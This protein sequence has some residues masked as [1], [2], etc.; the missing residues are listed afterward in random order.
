MNYSETLN[1]FKEYYANIL[2][3]Q[4]H[5]KSKA[6]QTVKLL[7]ELIFSNMSLMQIR[8]VFCLEDAKV[9]TQNYLTEDGEANIKHVV[10]NKFTFQK[11]QAINNIGGYYT[12]YFDGSDW[13]FKGEVVNISDYG[14]RYS[15]TAIE[16][17]TIIINYIP[18]TARKEQLDII[19]K[20]VGVTSQF[21][22]NLI[23]SPKL[24]YPQYSRLFPSDSTSDLQGGYSDYYVY[25]DNYITDNPPTDAYIVGNTDYAADWLSLTDGGASITPQNGSVYVV[26]T[27]GLYYD[28]IFVFT[29]ELKDENNNIIRQGHYELYQ[30]IGG[31]LRYSDMQSIDNN[32]DEP[33]FRQILGLKIIYNSINHTQGEID[34]A[35]YKFW[36]GDVITKWTDNTIIYEYPQKYSQIMQIANYKGVLP[37]PIGATIQLTQ[38][39]E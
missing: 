18:Y 11:S 19:G 20:W 8:D 25:D 24:S 10:V 1:L 26:K 30:S 4:Y 36:G 17:D 6:T 13:L 39:G 37:A 29:G 28:K 34:D 7:V 32:I 2:I 35:I 5:S 9:F 27:D 14:I 12:F 22:I 33:S 21:N 16:G 23:I 15:D 3:V 38:I 31:Q